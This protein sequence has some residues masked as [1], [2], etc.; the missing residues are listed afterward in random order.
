MDGRR[1]LN[2]EMQNGLYGGD[3]VF[4]VMRD[5]LCLEKRNGAGKSRCELRDGSTRGRSNS[6]RSGDIDLRRYSSLY[7]HGVNH[8][9]GHELRDLLGST[10]W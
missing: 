9:R 1:R 7:L 5:R 2:E 8:L 3:E 6:Q 10:A 4:L